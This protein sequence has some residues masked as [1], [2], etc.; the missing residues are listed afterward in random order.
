MVSESAW[1]LLAMGAR[2][3]FS[4]M[5]MR[6][7]CHVDQGGHDEHAPRRVE[8]LGLLFRT[9]DRHSVMFQRSKSI[10]QTPIGYGKLD[11]LYFP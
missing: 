7:D 1:T 2:L 9:L 8:S 3:L 11:F 10:A 6:F 5:F 4:D